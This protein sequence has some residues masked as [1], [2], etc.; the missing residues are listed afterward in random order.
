MLLRALFSTFDFEPLER[1]PRVNLSQLATVDKP[2]EPV[3]L[4]FTRKR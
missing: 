3:H 1:A 4:T 2:L